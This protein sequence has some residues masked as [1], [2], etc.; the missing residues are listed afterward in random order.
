MAF[1]L[2]SFRSLRIPWRFRRGPEASGVEV[3]L[4]F[5][6]SVRRARY[7]SFAGCLSFLK[8]LET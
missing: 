5:L 2:D 7:T 6:D 3:I 8:E 4:A 1:R